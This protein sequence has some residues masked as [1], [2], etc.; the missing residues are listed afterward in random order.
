MP[1]LG[2][3][4]SL[5]PLACGESLAG[6]RLGRLGV[7]AL[8]KP[9]WKIIEG[10]PLP[11]DHAVY[12]AY[13]GRPTPD[14]ACARDPVTYFDSTVGGWPCGCDC[15]D[16]IYAGEFVC[17]QEQT[18]PHQRVAQVGTISEFLRWFDA[19]GPAPTRQ[20]GQRPASR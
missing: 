5:L 4:F 13:V 16:E 19:V 12:H 6:R 11:E 1:S 15:G 10:E 2:A 17:G 7:D 18:A 20:P 14:N 3:L 8:G 9:G